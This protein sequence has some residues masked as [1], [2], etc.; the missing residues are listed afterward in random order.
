MQ[1]HR[2]ELSWACFVS[3]CLVFPIFG[4]SSWFVPLELCLL[5]RQPSFSLLGLLG[6]SLCCL[7]PVLLLNFSASWV[8]AISHLPKQSQ[9]LCQD[10]YR[11]PSALYKTCFLCLPF[12]RA[13]SL[14]W[15]TFSHAVFEMFFLPAV[16]VRLL[17]RGWAGHCASCTLFPGQAWPTKCCCATTDR[18]WFILGDLLSFGK[19]VGEKL[20]KL[21][22]FVLK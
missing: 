11:F 21:H 2:T 15:L 13:P 19:S 4:L 8:L 22:A 10:N 7:I 14:W 9:R 16:P 6:C 17:W 20:E 3:L 18:P 12:S 5:L 1:Y